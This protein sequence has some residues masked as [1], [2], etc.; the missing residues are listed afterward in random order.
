M[1]EV[2]DDEE[3]EDVMRGRK[4]GIGTQGMEME[5]EEDDMDKK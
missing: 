4:R 3:E 5:E 2:S 1:Y